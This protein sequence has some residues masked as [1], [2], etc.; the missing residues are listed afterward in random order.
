MRFPRG[1]DIQSGAFVLFA[2]VVLISFATIATVVVTCRV[3]GIE[4]ACFA[5]DPAI[6][7]EIK[8][9]VDSIVAILLALMAGARNPAPHAPPERTSERQD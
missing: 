6:T 9:F 5:N 8:D 4:R 7:P 1:I 2:F 3:F